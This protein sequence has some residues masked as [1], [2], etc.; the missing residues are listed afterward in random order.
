MSLK[1]NSQIQV[2]NEKMM[3][4]QRFE[5]RFPS[6]PLCGCYTQGEIGPRAIYVEHPAKAAST[7]SMRGGVALQGFTVVFGV[8]VCPTVLDAKAR[9]FEKLSPS[10]I[11]KYFEKD[12]KLI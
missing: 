3:D 4:A 8:F 2:N 1:I 6:L 10:K 12:F 11:Q 9:E 7:V 5:N